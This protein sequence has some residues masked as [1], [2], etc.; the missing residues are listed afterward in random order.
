MICLKPSLGSAPPMNVPLMKN[1]GVAVDLELAELGH[2]GLD[3]LL[4]L[5]AGHVGLELRD[6]EARFLRDREQ[7]R[8]AEL[9]RVTRLRV[10]VEAL[11]PDQRSCTPVLALLRARAHA[12]RCAAFATCGWT[13]MSL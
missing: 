8:L 11:L 3:E 5:V 7:V 2:V 4:A 10:G 13:T 6:V 9:R 1:A 12:A